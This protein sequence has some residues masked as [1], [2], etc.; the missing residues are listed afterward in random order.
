MT[1][2]SGPEPQGLPAQIGNADPIVFVKDGHVFADS[3]EVA[4]YFEK[5]HD[6]VMKAIRALIKTEPDLGVRNFSETPYVEA[7]NGQTYKCFVMD[8]EGFELLGMGFTGKKAL[9]WKISYVRAFKTMEAQLIYRA[10]PSMDYSDPTV[11]LGVMSHLQSQIT[12]KDEV[13]TQQSQRLVKLN[14]IEGA[15]GN[16]P[17]TDAAKVLK[18]KPRFL[19]KFLQE[20]RWIYKRPSSHHW[21]AYQRL[22]PKYLDHRDGS[23]VDDDGERHFFSYAVV[24]PAGIVMLA[25]MLIAAEQAKAEVK[26]DTSRP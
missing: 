7:Q 11:L 25:E 1:E 2:Y 8:R 5:R 23:Y 21:L 15:T 6:D 3:R 24:T 14:R 22:M 10:P 13:I 20:N 17:I 12:A 16:L 26:Y 18:V 4:A 9:R 19:T